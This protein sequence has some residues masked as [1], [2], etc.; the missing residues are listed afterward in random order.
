MIA[1]GLLAAAL[2]AAADPPATSPLFRQITVADGAV[3]ALGEP[4]TEGRL[5]RDLGGGVHELRRGTFSGAERLAVTV[6]TDG[7]VQ[8]M[9]FTYA[10]E[11]T[12]DEVVS[13]YQPRF[14]TPHP[15]WRD[16]ADIGAWWADE[17]A[18]LEILRPT[19]EAPAVMA[20][21]IAH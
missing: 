18:R 16:G 11:V 17:A 9:T 15:L 21:L 13:R 2:H 19:P 3:I 10:G 5:A 4:F 6:S 8:A 12:F 20:R 14:G 7:R 1:G